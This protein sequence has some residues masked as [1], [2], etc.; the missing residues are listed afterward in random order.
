VAHLHFVTNEVAAARVRQMGEDP[1]HV[2]NYGSPGIDAIRHLRRL[3]REELAH[4]LGFSLLERN[5]LVTFHP[6]T[7]DPAPASRQFSEV[8][9]ALAALGPR[10]GLL[11]THAN[12]DTGGRAINRMIGEFASGRANA[13]AYES[14]GSDLYL[15]TLAEVD[16][17]VGNSSSA[18][19]EAPTLR[20]PA[21]NIGD[22]QQGRLQASS[23]LNCAPV[24]AEIQR[25]IEQAF[26]LDCSGTVNPYGD[27]ASATRIAEALAAL[28]DPR[29]LVRKKFHEL[30]K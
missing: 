5:V 29:K 7:I 21:V 15:N 13:R 26:A 2:F 20:T 18:L 27:G 4:A 6:A 1:A 24:A 14:L 10:V 3:S 19:Y 11:L 12:A 9:Q 30:A 22:R 28:D 25:A 17:V 16:A 8:L 23:V